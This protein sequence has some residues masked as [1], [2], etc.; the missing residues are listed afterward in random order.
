MLNRVG[1]NGLGSRLWCIALLVIGLIS[2]TGCG[3]APDRMA[4][5]TTPGQPGMVSMTGRMS[6]VEMFNAGPCDLDI[7]IYQLD[8]SVT[9]YHT[10]KAERALL[11]NFQT[12]G[13][14]RYRNVDG[15]DDP[16]TIRLRL[17]G[18]G[19]WDRSSDDD[20]EEY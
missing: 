11:R 2:P 6:R 18:S 3:L 10:L 5:V 8:G 16:T 1:C 4:V 12:G 14:I 7:E 20:S 15:C 19:R 9:E 13:E 17:K